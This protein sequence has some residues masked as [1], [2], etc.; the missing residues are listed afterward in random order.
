MSELIAG[1]YEILEEIGRGG[2]GSV[3][4]AY[5]QNLDR[6]VAIKILSPE[7]ASDPDFRAR[8]QRE[9]KIVARLVHPN[10]VA[11][12][13]IEPH[14]NT[15]C[16]IMEYVDGQSLQKLIEAAA[17]DERTTLLIGAQIA[18]ALHYAH[19]HGVIHR[20]VKP[21]NILVTP[22]KVAKITD[23]GIARFREGK[24]RTQTGVSMGT[25]R[26]MSPE[27]LTG[28]ELDGRCDLY[29]L[30]V[31]L[32]YCLTGRVPF[33]GENAFAVATR[34]IYDTPTPPSQYNPAITS[35]AERIILRALE[36]NKEAR[37]AN[38][39]EMAR[40]LEEAGGAKVPMLIAPTA[41]ATVV[42]QGETK[43]LDFSTPA[44]APVASLSSATPTGI[45]RLETSQSEKQPHPTTPAFLDEFVEQAIPEHAA[46]RRNEGIAALREWIKANWGIVAMVVI[47]VGTSFIA[48]LQLKGQ[49]RLGQPLGQVSDDATG[50]AAEATYKQLLDA[51]DRDV[52]EGHQLDALQRV[53]AFKTMYPNYEPKVIDALIDRLTAGLPLSEAERLAQ[54]REQKGKKLLGDAKKAPLARA[55]LRAAQELYAGL[56]KI[57][58]AGEGV[59][60]LLDQATSATRLTQVEAEQ[61][62]VAFERARRRLNSPNADERLAAE[63]DLI[64][65]VCLAPEKFEYWL[66]LASF[67]RTE[68][69]LDDARVL[70]RYVE[71]NALKTS[72]A[73]QRA[74]RELRM[75]EQ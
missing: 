65:A 67:Y 50:A 10:I 36:K 33:D 13:D 49:D 69:L 43:M 46:P 41:D 66:E 62:T 7:L 44:H 3:Y 57:G 1:K 52:R 63:Q 27:Q 8:F 59:L 55:Y 23:F 68:G 32:Y 31:C 25:P 48:L 56:G 18:R 34:H 29:S 47:L 9:A 4:K 20:D 2:M 38:G 19:E 35:A 42:P 64:D 26:F 21:D 24:F 54:R 74:A 53:Q 70:L 15:C 28:H 60:R 40:A 12:Y 22:Q 45:R 5:Q 58:S 75:L 11:V 71:N 72:E 39:E 30:G 14:A 73:Y 6:I 37:F 17:L 61:A 16:I 51:V